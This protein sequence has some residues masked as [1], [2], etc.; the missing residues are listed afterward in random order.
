MARGEGRS[1]GPSPGLASLHDDPAAP[2]AA[3][4]PVAHADGPDPSTGPAALS[5]PHRPGGPAS[6]AVSR[7]ALTPAAT[8]EPDVSPKRFADRRAA[9][10]ALAE[11][12]S[13]ASSAGA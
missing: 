4:R 11:R 8:L 5:G 12:L 6:R 13:G 10:R 3:A 9:G 7:A 1:P 2:T